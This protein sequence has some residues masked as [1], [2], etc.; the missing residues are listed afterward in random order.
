MRNID[1]NELREIQINILNVVA[2]FCN[3]NGLNYCLGYGTLIGAVRHKGFIPWDDDIDIV[4]LRSDY[5]KFINSFNDFDSKYK[6]YT[7]TNTDWFPY[8]FAKV[9][10]ENSIIKEDS[11]NME[12]TI[13]INIDVFPI[14]NIPND[15]KQQKKMFNEVGKHRNILN[16]N[17]VVINS[18]RAFYKNLIL[19]VGKIVF[20]IIKP[21]TIVRK[22][23]NIATKF[24]GKTT[25]K[26]G[27]IVWGY[28][29]REIVPRSLFDS[30]IKMKFS[31]NEYNV[32]V[33]YHEWLTSNYG[34][35]MELPPIEKRVS[36]HDFKAYI[37]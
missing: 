8:P 26:V 31:E 23:I 35:Y 22:I 2:D 1:I 27:N 4:L 28:G 21:N 24:N 18:K 3:K 5:D 15:I 30:A 12:K 36:H 14:D 19:Y 9:S 20:C 34:N 37:K 17:S 7:A 32:P 10:Y 25:E 33:G 13:G 11:D 16:V 29:E 6:V